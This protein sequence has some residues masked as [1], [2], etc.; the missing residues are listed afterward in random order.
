MGPLRKLYT[1]VDMVRLDVP[2]QYDTES[3]NDVQ[4]MPRERT[5]APQQAE[6]QDKA[7]RMAWP[8]GKIVSNAAEAS[9]RFVERMSGNFDGFDGRLRIA[10]RAAAVQGSRWTR[11]ELNK[12][13]SQGL[14]A[15]L[16]ELVDEYKHDPSPESKRRV[17]MMPSGSAGWR[18]PWVYIGRST[19]GAVSRL[20]SGAMGSDGERR[21]TEA[22]R[23]CATSCSGKQRATMRRR[24]FG[25]S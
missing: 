14:Q 2:L 21:A 9:A 17:T 10:I 24:R 12:R 25:A 1:M 16:D 5:A 13:L 20:P 15:R 4:L 23:W 19:E 7:P 11:E 3:A 8:G 22:G 6:R 18:P